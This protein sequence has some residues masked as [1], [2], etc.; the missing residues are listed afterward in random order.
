MSASACTFCGTTTMAE[1]CSETRER[2]AMSEFQTGL[3][4]LVLG[5]FGGFVWGMELATRRCE[6]ILKRRAGEGRDA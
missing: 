3:L 4:M 5:I 6:R 2:E 1:N